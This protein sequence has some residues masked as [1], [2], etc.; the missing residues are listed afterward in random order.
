[1]A[2][3]PVNGARTTAGKAAGPFIGA[4]HDHGFLSAESRSNAS[5][6]MPVHRRMQR[7]AGCPHERYD[8]LPFSCPSDQ[9]LGMYGP[10]PLACQEIIGNQNGVISRKQALAAGLG[11]DV[12]VRLVGSG[13]LRPMW[14]G[15]YSVFNAQS[16]RGAELW[17]AVLH[18]G[19]GA[20]L[21][22]QTA[23]EMQGLSDEP[24]S[25]IHVTIPEARR[26]EPV[27]GIVIHRSGRVQSARH[28]VLLPPRTRI[29]ESVLDLVQQATTFDRA[30]A[31]AAVAC[32]R[33]LT[34]ADLIAIAMDD[35]KK[36]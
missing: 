22:H 10:L 35:R 24:S 31:W 14:R 36:L 7:E 23:A 5:G 26:V 6:I 18:A 27:G 8:R 25:L 9:A 1:M 13:R 28:P 11:P 4:F 17:A 21:S 3:F 20:V 30:F 29:E 12:I 32:Q 2:A 19:P 34:R 16:T 15:V 33:R